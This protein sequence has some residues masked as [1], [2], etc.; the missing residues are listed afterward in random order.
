MLKVCVYNLKTRRKYGVIISVRGS[1]KKNISP[2][3]E[4]SSAAARELKKQE[5]Y[6]QTENSLGKAGNM[7]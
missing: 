1:R 7:F 5:E 3:S 2:G 4:P 6:E